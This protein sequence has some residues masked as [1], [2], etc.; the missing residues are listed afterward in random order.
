MSNIV[1]V[2]LLFGTLF[3]ATHYVA[4]ILNLYWLYQW[5]DI[6]MHFWGGILI[7]LGTFVLARLRLLPRYIKKRYI[8]SIAILFIVTWELF[9]YLFGIASAPI[10]IPDT[11]LDVIVGFAGVYIG[12]LVLRKNNLRI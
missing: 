11:I 4:T 3:A 12:Y 6:F 10:N 5:F 2:F 1:K 8:L 7:T 9:E